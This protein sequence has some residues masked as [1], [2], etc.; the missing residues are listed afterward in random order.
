MLNMDAIEFSIISAQAELTL[1]FDLFKFLYNN[2][3]F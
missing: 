3:F 1:S 2:I